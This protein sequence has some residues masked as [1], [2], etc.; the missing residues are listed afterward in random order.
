MNRHRYQQCHPYHSIT[1]QSSL[2]EWLVRELL[3]QIL[4]QV[5]FFHDDGHGLK[6]SRSA[7]FQ[8][9]HYTVLV[10]TIGDVRQ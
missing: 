5:A 6:T 10:L 3:C 4:L 9:E 1:E 7:I 2:P 8:L